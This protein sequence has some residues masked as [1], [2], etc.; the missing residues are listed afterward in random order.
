MG[1]FDDWYTIFKKYQIAIWTREERG[2]VTK[3][4]VQKG[5]GH[6]VRANAGLRVLIYYRT[7][8]PDEARVS[9]RS[10]SRSGTF[11]KE[12]R[13]LAA[14]GGHW[15]VRSLSGPARRAGTQ[16]TRLFVK[17][18]MRRDVD[19]FLRTLESHTKPWRILSETK[20]IPM[21]AGAALPALAAM[22]ETRSQPGH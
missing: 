17:R 5:G 20:I 14:D 16:L 1:Y 15:T 12:E 13:T 7:R 19:S 21:G 4:I 3:Y 2:I 22:A 8:I 10:C 6:V 9:R 11:R 18:R